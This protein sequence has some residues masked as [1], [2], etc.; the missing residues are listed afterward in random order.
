MFCTQCGCKNNKTARF[1]NACGKAIESPPVSKK[2]SY[3]GALFLLILLAILI[4]ETTSNPD[5]V[6]KILEFFNYYQE[7]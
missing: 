2:E 5:V 6:A 1:C 4:F 3:L 7:Y